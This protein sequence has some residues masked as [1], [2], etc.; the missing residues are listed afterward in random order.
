MTVVILLYTQPCWASKVSIHLW[1]F[2]TVHATHSSYTL[3]IVVN[4]VTNKVARLIGESETHRFLN[5]AL[6]QGA[7]RKKGVMTLVC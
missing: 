2:L 7:P 1:F 6:Y 5:M 4:S 3:C